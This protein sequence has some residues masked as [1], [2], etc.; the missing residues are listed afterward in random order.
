MG[1]VAFLAIPVS[2]RMDL[3]FAHFLFQFFVTGQAEIRAFGQEEG[4][5]FGL[6]GVMAFCAFPVTDRLMS[7]LGRLQPFLK[8]RM[9]RKAEGSLFIGS[10]SLDVASVGIVAGQTLSIFKGIVV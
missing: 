8:V 7:A 9:A 1:L 2:R 5:Q 3:L 10:Y 6:V 4:I